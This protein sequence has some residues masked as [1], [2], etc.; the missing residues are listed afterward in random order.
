MSSEQIKEKGG[1]RRSRLALATWILGLLC[2][3]GADPI[4]AQNAQTKQGVGSGDPTLSDSEVHIVK[5]ALPLM[6]IELKFSEVAQTKC[7]DPRT[8]KLA[9]GIRA[10]FSTIRDELEAAARAHALSYLEELEDSQKKEVLQL[11]QLPKGAVFDKKYCD[12]TSSTLVEMA[13]ALEGPVYADDIKQVVERSKQAARAHGDQAQALIT[14][15][16]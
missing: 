3:F 4:L 2:W 5:Y 8:L 6:L 16:H 9:E 10:D 14:E 13:M 7:S 11:S 12:K 15:I 1:L